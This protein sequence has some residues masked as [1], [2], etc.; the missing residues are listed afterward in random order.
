MPRV[1][2]WR[3]LLFFRHVSPAEIDGM[4]FYTLRHWGDLAQIELDAKAAAHLPG[5]A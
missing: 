3:A 2:K 4:D 1:A 5:R